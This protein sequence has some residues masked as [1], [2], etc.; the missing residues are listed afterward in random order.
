MKKYNGVEILPQGQRTGHS[1]Q[2]V[3]SILIHDLLSVASEGKGE[4]GS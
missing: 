1:V 2:I 4:H 3:H